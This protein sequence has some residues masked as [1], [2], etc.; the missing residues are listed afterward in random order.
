MNRTSEIN[1]L[2]EILATSLAARPDLN[3]RLQSLLAPRS[4]NQGAKQ[5][6]KIPSMKELKQSARETFIRLH[7]KEKLKQQLA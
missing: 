6:E 7:I 5:E 2:T 1:E 3:K 4:V